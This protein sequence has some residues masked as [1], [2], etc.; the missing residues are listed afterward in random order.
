MSQ[1]QVDSPNVPAPNPTVG[2]PAVVTPDRDLVAEKQAE[3][4]ANRNEVA[5][6]QNRFL[7]RK[8]T[9]PERPIQASPEFETLMFE[10]AANNPFATLK[11]PAPSTFVPNLAVS[12][13]LLAYM[14]H[15]MAGTK[16][17]LDNCLGWAPPISQ[18][19]IAMIM[20]IQILR[21]MDSASALPPGS[22]LH[23]FLTQ[24]MS[25]FPLHDLWI[26]GPL[27]A[28]FRNM[29]AFWPSA[30]DR[31]GNVTPS[32][33]TLPGWS[34]TNFYRLNGAAPVASPSINNLLPNIAAFISR[35]RSV[36][37]TAITANMTQATFAT[38]TD[39]P[40]RAAH[41]FQSVLNDGVNEQWI[42][43]S[44]GMAF[45]YPDNLNMWQA[46]AYRL[47]ANAIPADLNAGQ[48]AGNINDS[49][50]SFFRFDNNQHHWFG[51]CAA[52]MSKYC[53]FFNGSAPL[54]EVMPNCSASGAVKLR[55]QDN[56]DI[57]AVPA[58]TAPVAG[59]PAVAGYRSLRHTARLVMNGRLALEDIP[60]AH[61]YAAST[62]GINMYS[63][64]A[65]QQVFRQGP[66]WTLGPDTDGRDSIELLPGI[67][68]TIVR[69]YHS[70]VRIA[71]HK[72]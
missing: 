15:L 70:D 27:V 2:T 45:A 62:F 39:G 54:A 16:R 4:A 32:L 17:W 53:Q 40:A 52:I 38:H 14:D 20:Y 33:P 57:R 12:F 3:S 37:N 25:T 19:Y 65:H 64:Q 59:P 1:M 60:T 66:F 8:Q 7:A 5:K 55:E 23:T 29:S 10:A 34:R 56:S 68:S 48:A 42:F 72:Q 47:N 18:M 11:N 26:P 36:C 67:L 44:P 28:V 31:F 46:A 6:K 71:A 49:W 35:L 51:S 58:W 41:L 9:A 13:Y 30:S 21:A 22:E 50:I 24:F 63:S 43:S 69:Q 61:V